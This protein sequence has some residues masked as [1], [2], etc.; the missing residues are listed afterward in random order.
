MVV[1]YLRKVVKVP[2]MQCPVVYARASRAAG[3][4]FTSNEGLSYCRELCLKGVIF[5]SE[6]IEFRSPHSRAI[7]ETLQFH[8][9][10]ERMEKV[11]RTF[12]QE[13]SDCCLMN[14]GNAVAMTAE[15]QP[16]TCWMTWC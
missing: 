15:Q 12:G 2:Y 10:K 7:P 11:R 1:N 4:F 13:A 8:L 16:M 6:V 3:T 9:G 14:K 5:E